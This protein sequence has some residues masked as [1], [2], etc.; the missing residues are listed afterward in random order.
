MGRKLPLMAEDRTP[1]GF[2]F[3]LPL[4]MDNLSRWRAR[5]RV[6]R[7]HGRAVRKRRTPCRRNHRRRLVIGGLSTL[8]FG[9]STFLYP[10]R[11]SNAVD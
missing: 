10:E 8:I 5:C 4:A 11:I 9:R 2:L 3:S 7:G 1:I 6:T